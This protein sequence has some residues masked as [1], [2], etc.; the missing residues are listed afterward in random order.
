[1]VRDGRY[2][3]TDDGSILFVGKFTVRGP[4]METYQ[5]NKEYCQIYG[6]HGWKDN[7]LRRIYFLIILLFCVSSLLVITSTRDGLVDPVF[8]HDGQ[9]EFSDV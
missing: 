8:L 1:M 7:L 4:A 9:L 2:S 5:C 3:G 6:S